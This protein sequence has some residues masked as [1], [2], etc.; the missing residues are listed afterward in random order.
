MEGFPPCCLFLAAQDEL[1]PPVHSM[2][3]KAALDRAGIPCRMEIG[4]VGGHG[5]ADGAGSCMD[6]WPERA[7]AWYE[8][9]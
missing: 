2:L 1:V 8:G 9:L 3:L 7:A 5:F 4:P 6:G